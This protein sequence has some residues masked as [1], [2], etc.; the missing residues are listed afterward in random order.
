[1]KLPG[2]LNI[3]P[4][5][6]RLASWL[7]TRNA[8]RLSGTLNILPGLRWVVDGARWRVPLM[9]WILTVGFMFS[10]MA[11][12]EGRLPVISQQYTGATY[13][14]LC[15]GFAFCMSV[16]AVYQYQPYIDNSWHVRPYKQWWRIA[17]AL[18]PF[19]GLTVPEL[20]VTAMH[21]GEP[22]ITTW[23]AWGSPTKIGHT[24]LLPFMGYIMPS[25][26]WPA[27]FRTPNERKAW[28]FRALIVAGFLGWAFFA[29]V[30]DNFITPRP[31]TH[32]VHV[33]DG[34]PWQRPEFWRG[35]AD[36]PFRD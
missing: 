12:P 19:L 6:L 5:L 25:V 4:Q 20:V 1:M 28:I 32:C 36:C 22:N 35:Y 21:Y 31:D 7:F 10:L 30:N 8:M 9:G 24:L 18:V 34:W 15:L 2:S 13:G 29:I 11:G 3:P 33:S 26:M 27:V 16:I 23:E 17:L 14:D